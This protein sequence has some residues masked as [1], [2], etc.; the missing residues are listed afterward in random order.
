ME[1][2][3]ATIESL[4]PKQ[5]IKNG[6]VF[7]ALIFARKFTDIRSLILTICTFFLFCFLASS[8]YLLNDVVDYESDRKHPKKKFR[9]IASG[10]VSKKVAIFIS[11]LL[12]LSSISISL[13]INPYLTLIMVAY[14]V[15]NLL[16]TFYFKHIVIID[17]FMIAIGFVLRAFAGVVVIGVSFSPWFVVII[18]LLTLFLG[19]MKRRQ[20]FVEVAKN[21]G[22]KRKVLDKYSVHM[23]DQMSNIVLPCTL[24]GYIL[25]TFNTFHT[26][27]FILTIPCVVYGIFRYLYLVYKKGLGESPTETLI[28]DIPLFLAVV[29]WALLSAMLI[30]FFE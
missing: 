19:I 25:F 20:E 4:R 2:F 8:I 30:Y 12:A 17:I 27:Y 21:G 16:Y 26:H 3:K 11:I 15:N 28:K 14:T 24:M 29:I 22:E 6:F 7:A 9:P 18:F 23:L 5:W 10:K 13:V 1:E